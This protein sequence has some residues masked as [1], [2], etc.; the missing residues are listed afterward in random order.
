MGRRARHI[1]AW[2]ARIDVLLQGAASGWGVS[3]LAARAVDG[4]ADVPICSDHANPDERNTPPDQ[5]GPL[6]PICQVGCCAAFV[7]APD[8]AVSPRLADRA[9]LAFPHYSIA[10]P[11][12]PPRG[13]PQ[14][15]APP[16]LSDAG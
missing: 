6:C 11:R 3:V 9:P 8:L 4:I 5:H 14:A 13:L 16:L 1:L 7:V 15:R 2:V 12:G 10:E